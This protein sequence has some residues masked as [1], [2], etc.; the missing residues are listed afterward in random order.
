MG[1]VS[2]T[3]DGMDAIVEPTGK[4]SRRVSE[5]PSMPYDNQ[6][7]HAHYRFPRLLGSG[8]QNVY[9]QA[10]DHIHFTSH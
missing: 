3:V 1:G 4:Y 10:H 6:V 9:I 7:S 8:R 2:E 5:I